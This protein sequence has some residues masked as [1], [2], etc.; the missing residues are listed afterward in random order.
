MKKIALII[1][2]L[3]SSSLLAVAQNL[4]DL[5]REIADTTMSPYCPGMTISACPSPK[6]RD[7]RGQIKT[8][9][10]QGYTKKAV[11]NQLKIAFGKEINGMPDKKGF[12][13]FAWAFPIVFI[14]IGLFLIYG[15]YRNTKK[16]RALE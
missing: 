2:F 9:F 8:W 16:A 5:T 7:L 11:R 4:D 13:L 12:G 3:L 1:I 15:V 6:A 14:L 10:E